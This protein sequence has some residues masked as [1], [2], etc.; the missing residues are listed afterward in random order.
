MNVPQA[1][2]NL[3][4]CQAF[5]GHNPDIITCIEQIKDKEFYIED[6]EKDKFTKRVNQSTPGKSCKICN[7]QQK[8][9]ILLPIDNKFIK[10][11]QGGIAD[12]AVFNEQDFHFVEFKTNAE[13]NNDNSVKLTYDKAMSQLKETLTLFENNIKSIGIDFKKQVDIECNIIVSESFPRNNAIEMTNA[14]YFAEQTNG[15]PLNFENEIH[16]R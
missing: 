8:V 16:L 10:I 12:A 3:K 14:I 6:D 13:G 1:V 9:A 5:K 11:C 15:I 4:L 7:P 2:K